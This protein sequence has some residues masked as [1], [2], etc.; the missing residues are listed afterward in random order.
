MA[1]NYLYCD[2]TNRVM[3]SIAGT[4]VAGIIRTVIQIIL[5]RYIVLPF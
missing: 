3:D 2:N 5:Y 1:L 4:I